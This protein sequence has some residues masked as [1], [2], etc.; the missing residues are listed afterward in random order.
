MM[1]RAVDWDYFEDLTGIDEIQTEHQS[2][3][4][5]K[6]EQH[7][8]QGEQEVKDG[9]QNDL[10]LKEFRT[11]LEADFKLPEIAHSNPIT[12]YDLLRYLTLIYR[13]LQGFE[14]LK[15]V[16]SEPAVEET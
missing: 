13:L 1:A 12:N 10:L 14:E 6:E 15:G 9:S 2:T 5:P 16:V 4:K 7:E 3:G 8:D 11:M